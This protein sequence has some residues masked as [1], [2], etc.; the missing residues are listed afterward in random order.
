MT[1]ALFVGAGNIIFPPFIGLRAGENFWYATGGFLITGVGLP[2]LALIAMA[3][4]NGS[5]VELTRPAGKLFGLLLSLIC[6]M[7]LGPLFGAPRTATVS[8]EI[9][10]NPLFSGHV[11]LS[12]FS[13]LFFIAVVL[14]SLNPL[15]LIDIVGKFLSPIKVASLGALGLY[16]FWRPAGNELFTFPEYV[17]NPL[18]SGMINGYLTMDTLAALVFSIII[19]N[20]IKSHG[21]DSS[22]RITRYMVIT[23]LIA[24]VGLTYVYISLFYLGAYSLPLARSA[25][26]GADVLHA[27][28]VNGFGYQGSVFLAFIIT[29]ACLVTAIGLTS[30]CASYFSQITGKSYKMFVVILAAVSMLLSNLGLTEI[31]HFSLPALTSVYPPFIVLVIYGALAKPGE[32]SVALCMPATLVAF[33]IGTLQS[34]VPAEDLPWVAGNLPF[35]KE[36]MAWIIPTIVVFMLSA[37][38]LK[39]KKPVP[40]EN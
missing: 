34:V 26:N 3:R 17:E 39:Y 2:V 28:I 8:Y 36:G 1:F 30:A 25:T 24:A 19:V 38:C 12:A 35:Y 27:F 7:A 15:K 18:S 11:P 32:H 33:I 16:A 37:V 31:I 20:A 5:L 21:V 6:Y 14:C 22:Q 9:G 29:V 23:G 40:V 13:L 4:N 10:I